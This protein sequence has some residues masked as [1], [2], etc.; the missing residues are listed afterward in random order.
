MVKRL[1]E[2]RKNKKGFTLVELIVVIVIILV[3]AA[4]MVPNVL[5]YINKAN[6]ANCKSDAASILVQLQAD[7]TDFYS[8]PAKTGDYDA[9]TK[10]G[11]AT[12]VATYKADADANTYTYEISKDAKTR[13]EI[14]KFSYGN[15]QYYISWDENVWS[16]V[17]KRA[18]K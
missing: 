4:V 1:R 9:T 13:G 7:V 12:G 15:A 17:S 8:D 11:N 2:N 16:A 14:T 18:K 6:E 10:Y 3:L 5:K